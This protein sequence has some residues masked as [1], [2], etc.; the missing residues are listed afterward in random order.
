MGGGDT[1]LGIASTPLHVSSQAEVIRVER[2]NVQFFGTQSSCRGPHARL[3]IVAQLP[4]DWDSGIPDVGSEPAKFWAA[5]AIAKALFDISPTLC[6]P[7]SG[8]Y[9]DPKHT[10]Q[11]LH[12]LA[13]PVNPQFEVLAELRLSKATSFAEYLSPKLNVQVH[14]TMAV[15]VVYGSIWDKTND[16]PFLVG[17]RLIHEEI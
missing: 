8:Y 7:Q 16:S 15:V 2:I 5:P 1:Y 10:T 3:L 12:C 14:S 4:V 11:H 13:A 9:S 17:V 6:R